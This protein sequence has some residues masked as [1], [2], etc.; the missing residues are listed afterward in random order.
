MTAGSTQPSSPSNTA[1]GPNEE[2]EVDIHFTDEN[3]QGGQHS[4]L[5]YLYILLTFTVRELPVENLSA[6][7]N[8]PVPESSVENVIEIFVDDDCPGKQPTRIFV[9]SIY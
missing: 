4:S 3:S 1:C 6:M 9:S 7:N 5:G 8:A 2:T